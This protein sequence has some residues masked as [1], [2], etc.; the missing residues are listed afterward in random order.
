VQAAFVGGAT[1]FAVWQ[2]R[3]F[4]KNQ[5]I[6]RTLKVLSD[7]DV[8][9]YLGRSGKEMPASL[10]ASLALDAAMNI[11]IVE[12]GC[13]DFIAG[14]DTCL[15]REYLVFCDAATAVVN[16]FNFAAGFARRKLIDR[17][18]FL[19]SRSYVMTL[20]IE[21][22]KTVLAAEGRSH[23]DLTELEEFVQDAR[24]Y[25]EKNPALKPSTSVERNP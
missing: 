4:Q 16:Y 21:P 14:R 13:A 5:R 12:K 23:Y 19:E 2:Y 22:V 3:A 24:D 8:V 7:Y 15:K 20:I 11:A 1:I 9:R 18:L 10:A 17:D 6:E 25:L